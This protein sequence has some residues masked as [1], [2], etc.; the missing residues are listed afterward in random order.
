[1]TTL[2]YRALRSLVMSLILVVGGAA[3]ALA[4]AAVPTFTAVF[5]PN[6][7]TSGGSATLTFTIDN[8]TGSPAESIAFTGTLPAG[9]TI[10]SGS[11]SNSCGSSTFTATAGS[12]TMA[13]SGGRLGNG[14]SCTVSLPVTSSTLGTHTF[15][16]G[17]LTSTLGN[18][19]TASDDL[20]VSASTANFSKSYS[21]SAV[22]PGNPST[23]TYTFDVVVPA[24]GTF[25]EWRSAYMT[26]TLPTGLE[27]LTPLDLTATG[28]CNTLSYSVSETTGALTF[29][30]GPHQTEGTYSCTLTAAVTGDAPGS[31]GSS[32]EL[33]T[34]NAFGG[35]IAT[36]DAYAALIVNTPPVNG[37]NLIKSFDVTRAN[38]GDTVTLS[39]SLTNTDTLNDASGISFTDDLDAMLSGLA[40]T[41]A[42]PSD[43][44]GNGSTLSGS[45]TLTLSGG[46][47]AARGNCSFSVDVLIPAGASS[48]T[49]TNTTD[50]VTATLG[51][52]PYTGS[53]ATTTL[54]VYGED[55]TPPTF[56]KEFTDDPVA[57]GDTV[58][59]NYV[60]TNPS[61]T[62][63][64][65]DIAF[66][67]TLNSP[68][69][70][71]VS[72]GTGGVCGG[73]LTAVPEFSGGF[74][75]S[76]SGGS[77]AAGAS[78]TIPV[79]LLLDSATAPG[80]YATT[81]GTLTATSGGG[82]VSTAGASD[83]L[84]VQGG[85][86][87]SLV[88][89]FDDDYAQAGA[90]TGLSF[91]ITSAAESTSTV[92]DISF[93]DDLDAMLSGTTFSSL[94][95]DTC[96]GTLTGT[97]TL[98]YSG[99]TLDPGDSCTIALDIT[100]P[101]GAS[102]VKTNTTSTLLATASTA[103]DTTAAAA[104]DTISVLVAQ[105]LTLS[106]S[107]DITDPL[108][109]D[110]ITLTYT[111]TNPD[112]SYTYSN[113]SFS[114]SYTSALSTMA[115]SSL[116]IAGFCGGGTATGTTQGV[117][118]GMSL[119]PGESCDIPAILSVPAGAADGDYSTVSS[120]VSASLNGSGVTFDKLTA[121]FGIDTGLI[122]MAKAFSTSP[123]AAGDTVDVSYTLTNLSSSSALTGLTFTDD[124]DAALSGLVATGL[125][126]ST[127]GG[128][129]S[130]TST[131]SFSGGSLAAG[132]SCTITATLSVPGGAATG[133][134]TGTTSA[135]AGLAGTVAVSGVGAS[136]ALTVQSAVA[137]SFSKSISPAGIPQGGSST[138]TYVITNNDSSNAIS[139]LRFTDDLDAVLSGLEV[140]NG[141]GSDLCGT[142]S[143]VSG[144]SEVVLSG[145]SLA[146]SAS[147]TITLTVDVPQA[148]ALGSYTST[149][150]TLTE[151]GSYSAAAASAAF[152]VEPA[153]SFAKAFTPTSVALG[154]VST[155]TFTI[156][157]SASAIAATALDFT[158]NLPAGMEMAAA[159]NAA[160]TCTGGTLTA[161][162]GTGTL[163]YT[164]G[165]VAAGASC[166]VRADVTSTATGTLSNTSGDLTSSSGNSGT[167]AANLDVPEIS[168]DAP[169]ATDD[170]INGAEAPALTLSGSSSLIE[171]GQSVTLTV[172]DSGSGSVSGSA[173]V[174]GNAWSTT[175]DVSSLADGALSLTASVSDVAGT[176]T[177]SDTASLTK[178]ATAPDGH[179]VSF[180][181]SPIGAA[182]ESA[183]SFTFADAEVGASYSYTISSDGGGS[184]VTGSGT[185]ATATDQVSGLDLSALGSGTLTLSVVLTDT[186]GNA[187]TAV[188]DSATKDTTAP[189]I[190]FDS[191][192]AGDDLVGATEAAATTISGTTADLADGQT[193]T[194]VVTDSS[195]D[196]VTGTATTSG[197]A[198]SLE[199]D[200]SAL[201]DGALSLT[202]DVDDTAGNPATQ[203][204]ASLTK[205][206][207]APTGY[208]V[209]FD[210]DPLSAADADAASFTFAGAEVGA[211]YSY[212]IASDAGGSDV[213]GSG[214]IAT[215]TD[216]MTGI[217]LSGL[218]DGT[219][220]LTVA[221]TDPAGNAGDDVTDSTA[222][223]TDAPV[224]SFDSP[225]AEDDVINK[226]E[227]PAV[228]L[229]GSASGI[230]DG[231]T[232]TVVVTDSASDTV[233]GT[234]DVS[235]DVWS[236]TLDLS[237]LANGAL[238]LTADAEDASANPA[239]Q[240]TA[241]L[242]KDTRRPHGF[243][244]AFD[245]DPVSAA[246]ADAAS[247]SFT[248]AETGASFAYIIRS[249]GGGK[250]TGSGTI[251]NAAQQI[252]GIDLS[253]LS[254][255]TLKLVVTLTD[256]A[257]N[258][259]GKRRDE[260][261][262]DASQPAATLT[263]PDSA[264]SDP[265][266]VELTFDE[267]VTGLALTSLVVDNGTASDLTG[268]DD[269][270][271]FTVTPDHDGTV[272][273][274]LPEGAAQDSGGNDNTAAEQIEVTAALTGTPNPNPPADEDGDGIPDSFESSTAD[275]DG[276][277][278]PD[279]QDYDPQGY[280]YCE[281]DGRILSG[282]GLTVTGP[283]GSNSSVGIL[284]DINIVRDGSS[285]EYQWFAQRPGTY[286]VTY[287]YPASGVASTARTTS[288]TLDV[289]TLLPAN[290]AVIGSTEF[291]STGALADTS[292]AANPVFYDTFVIE[293]GDPNVLANNIPMT[294]C[295]PNPVTVSAVDNGGEANG[296]ATDSVIFT[297]S[298]GRVSSQDSVISYS[299][300]GSSTSGDDYTAPGGSVTIPAGD[301]QATVEITVLEDAL[302][303]GSETLT[304]TLTAVTAGD[305]TTMLSTTATDL[306][307]SA[308][309]VD[310]DFAVVAVSNDDL[311]A[312]ENGRDTA[313]MS[314][315]L[316]GQPT[317]R[318]QLSF[319][320]DAQC[321]VSPGTLSF[322]RGN[323]ATPQT[324]TIT[325]IDD[326][327]V[328]GSHSCQPTV[329]VTS[330]DTRYDAYALALAQVQILDDLVDQIRDRLTEVLKSDLEETVKTQQRYFSQM[331][332]GA[333][334]RVLA[335]QADLTCG[336][337]S[338]FD[339]DGAVQMTDGNG[340][341]DG[342]FGYDVYNCQSGSRE[343]LD[344]QFSLTRT[345]NI[346]TQAL[347]QFSKQRERFL[348]ESD[349]RGRFWGGYV[350]RTNVTGLA[351]GSING[352]GIN[353]GL[354]GAR[355][356]GDGL[357]LDYYAAAGLGH[358]R[359]KLDFEALPARIRA[360]GSYDYAAAFAGAALSGQREYD[361][362]LLTP[363]FGMD[364]A[365]ASASDADVR[366]SQL[367]QTDTGRI[368]IPDY[369]GGRIF[370]EL[371]FASLPGTT[372]EDSPTAQIRTAVAPRF[373]CEM[374][375]FD[376]DLD[377]GF[378]FSFSRDM[379][380]ALSG[381]SYGF[382][383]DYEHIDETDRLSLDFS[384]ERRFAN[385]QGAV[386]TRLSLPTADSLQIEH[387]VQ[388]D[389]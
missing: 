63:A 269:S 250:V 91:T 385:G 326:E 311:V 376:S 178:D 81:T 67:E 263:G 348:S 320:G 266:T 148:A 380:D 237:G 356:L 284:N 222:K 382:A 328:E 228:I 28:D 215:A 110:E 169:L 121:S 13:L 352:F 116:P 59:I 281:D 147:C 134:Y 272:S 31:Y 329:T 370:A 260:S 167:A 175:V 365:Y 11:Q 17:A 381:I 182:N 243:S 277:G 188:T 125:P 127:C 315:W 54:K 52:S 240:A 156:D 22:D 345:E 146:A 306:T 346:G 214:T 212:T 162:A 372:S 151:G 202:A 245:Q 330:N 89:S 364:L 185:I 279:A 368:D 288:G 278:I 347:L 186:V 233:T 361:S 56:T 42:L 293:A 117:F 252:T 78:C 317:G 267:A 343:I 15:T 270:Y 204:T 73:S 337:Q 251:S 83:T 192:L 58:T 331:S 297:I 198:W 299:L 334:E 30:G 12:D 256:A 355:E 300:G 314:F 189:G 357:F 354:Y 179:S 371:E 253:D 29:N 322:G 298:Q 319:A 262:L 205:D 323:F 168:F 50:A 353:G 137:P 234:A 142:G 374:S 303:E 3:A 157:N 6:S 358:H 141:T 16:T 14:S 226:A 307:G 289:T 97:S 133:S 349:L 276:D 265:F 236:V 164:G 9:V 152:T 111:L 316:Q 150:S 158:D 199:M 177:A 43:P 241:S 373:A 209:A 335:G 101:G 275:R 48:G 55:S 312:S 93:T 34:R 82:N 308:T 74:T 118:S 153:P 296:A 165:T 90:D 23:L 218:T 139:N 163:S 332:K 224:L 231:Q 261:T 379:F 154:G 187:A 171:N 85:A 170:V 109:G 344:G 57:P 159:P 99:G 206:S 362:F 271:S 166:T 287:T 227:A 280:F 286:T 5:S 53:A 342:T 282:G 389:F 79:T 194:V 62:T 20:A 339:V 221:L 183:A 238:T 70:T 304:L 69:G 181:Q 217:D 340:G 86:N 203:A 318:V 378:G 193:V 310:D 324:L 96:G 225:L 336:T 103:N 25:N 285:G 138:L 195:S 135:A 113:I 386:V 4:Q 321:A 273:I 235:A 140:S 208:S 136:A 1:M 24:G 249:S 84:T 246:E 122:S 172:T 207:V 248:G 38:V 105:P 77:L 60:L 126:T 363:R 201:A 325:A 333:L 211:S 123:V 173:S 131:V 196:T 367:G 350:S 191:P 223:D 220:T 36:D 94:T 254:D 39:F 149:A 242:T 229:S 49:Y 124:L 32:T 230:E 40:V 257:G 341:A 143:V 302:I 37:I 115:A 98:S 210:Q 102:G 359:Y 388:L 75:L 375:S 10:A 264:Q 64:I 132:D 200:L 197:N 155:L 387:G 219:L 274:S 232:V 33:Q 65:S 112:S 107:F 338:A 383:I 92:T 145:G 369:N 247:F 26:D 290:P 8:A 35:A 19:G 384:R 313:A 88:K 71:S 41:G 239:S 301:T 18:S 130:G 295:A 51:G 327:A 258:T 161:A 44:C 95:S 255:G 46:N 80:D 100:I 120:F 259:S 294:Q 144:T 291:G 190:D 305:A 104:S 244:V 360:K 61:S 268:S 114:D 351:D 160:T 87:L 76:F 7:I 366:A 119:A 184:D 47:L 309:V 216:Q 45:S 174:S 377:C 108:P 129:L 21:P 213:T 2:L 27:F 106:A 72:S 180:D 176:G 66:S 68:E 292:L 283:S 128:T